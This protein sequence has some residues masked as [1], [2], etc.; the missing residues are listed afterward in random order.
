M[1]YSELQKKKQAMVFGGKI[2]SDVVKKLKVYYQTGITTSEINAEATK[3]IRKSGAELSFNKVE[4]YHHATCLSVNEVV[5]HG[6]PCDYKLKDAD[7]LK[8]DIGVYYQGF[9]VDY[10]NTY[11]VNGSMN[12]KVENF[13]STGEKTLAKILKLA[14]DG[15][16]LGLISQTIEE[17]IE[18]AGYKVIY[19]LTG[20]GVGRELH[21]KPYIPG[22]L[23]GKI[24][25][26]ARMELGK[27]YALEVIYSLSDHEVVPANDD[28]WS[29]M[30]KNKCLSACFENSVFIDETGP[31]IL[32]NES[33]I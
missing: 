20:H 30:T 31:L 1:E 29:L 17:T 5:V 33:S 19:E 3:L 21:E 18:K 9:H 23:I 15:Q 26:T 32:V 12:T 25:K 11:V 10:G 28:G 16:Y 4:G 22:F 7:V 24:N 13:L 14:K 8:L 27:A 2:I 6:V